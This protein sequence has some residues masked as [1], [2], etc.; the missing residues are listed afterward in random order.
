VDNEVAQTN[1]WGGRG[2]EHQA[3][4]AFNYLSWEDDV[5]E[6]AYPWEEGDWALGEDGI[7]AWGHAPSNYIEW[8]LTNEM[9][10]DHYN[11][12]AI[13]HADGSVADIRALDDVLW[14]FN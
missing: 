9:G 3:R 13:L 6:F 14:D 1:E 10:D 5:L 8:D 7:E 4:W 2:I 12:W 11:Y